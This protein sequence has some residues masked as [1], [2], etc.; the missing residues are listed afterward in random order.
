MTVKSAMMTS[1]YD[2][3][4]ADGS[5]EP[6]PFDEGAGHVDPTKFFV[7]GLVVTSGVNDWLSFY[8]GPGIRLRYRRRPDGGQ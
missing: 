6:N 1:A 3:K 8:R 2:L 7:P 4:K 5:P